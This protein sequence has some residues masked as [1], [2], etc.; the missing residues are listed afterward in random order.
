MK[1]GPRWEK[2]LEDFGNGLYRYRG[3]RLTG[4][5]QVKNEADNVIT[6][7]PPGLEHKAGTQL[8]AVAWKRLLP[9]RGNTRRTPLGARDMVCMEL[10]DFGRLL[11]WAYRDKPKGDI[12]IWIQAKAAERVSISKEL[13]GLREWWETKGPR[14]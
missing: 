1:P 4:R 11:E 7:E 14:S 5:S 10:A 13:A 12:T 9:Q 3:K 6:T 2:D 8:L